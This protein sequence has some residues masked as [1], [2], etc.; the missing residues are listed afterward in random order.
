MLSGSRVRRLLR[1]NN[2]HQVVAVKMERRRWLQDAL[3]KEN[4]GDLIDWRWEEWGG[5]AVRLPLCGRLSHR[6]TSRKIRIWLIQP[7][8]QITNQA[9]DMKRQQEPIQPRRG[10]QFSLGC[11]TFRRDNIWCTESMSHIL[12]FLEFRIFILVIKF[13]EWIKSMLTGLYFVKK[14]L[15]VYAHIAY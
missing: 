8:H 13:R 11:S 6:A 15:M 9:S 5:V 12:H 14:L 2:F 3:C 10:A 7:T 1:K 4:H